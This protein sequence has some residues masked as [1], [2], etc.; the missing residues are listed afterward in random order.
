MHQYTQTS[1]RKLRPSKN[2][3]KNKEKNTEKFTEKNTG[4]FFCIFLCKFFRIF[5]KIQ[6]R[7]SCNLLQLSVSIFEP[8]VAQMLRKI[9]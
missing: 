5:F 8:Y 3:E 7:G 1:K 4:K 2:I 9:G 6:K